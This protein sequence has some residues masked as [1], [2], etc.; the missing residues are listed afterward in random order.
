MIRSI[1]LGLIALIFSLPTAQEAADDNGH[2]LNF[3]D[4]D[5]RAL[6]TTVADMTGARS[7]STRRS[8]GR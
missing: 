7:S 1:R 4:A 6:I 2:V 8:P 3:K 5:I